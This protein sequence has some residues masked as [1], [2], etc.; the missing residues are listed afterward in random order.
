MSLHERDSRRT[1]IISEREILCHAWGEDYP[2]DPI[3]RRPHWFPVIP[4]DAR[5]PARQPALSQCRLAPLVGIA[6]IF[7]KTSWN[8]PIPTWLGKFPGNLL[9]LLEIAR[10]PRSPLRILDFPGNQPAKPLVFKG[11]RRNPLNF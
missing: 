11:F 8:F 5:Q 4:A 3:P 6:G 10:I 2:R 1:K 9:K 7:R